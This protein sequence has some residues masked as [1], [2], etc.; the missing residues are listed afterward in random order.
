MRQ[1]S[2]SLGL[3]SSQGQN[4]RSPGAL[5]ADAIGLTAAGGGVVLPLLATQILRINLV[6]D[7]APALAL[8]VDSADEDI[9]RQSPRPRTEGVITRH[10]WIGI[11]FVGAIMATGTLLVL[12]ASLPG[13]LIEG[14]G[15]MR[16][17][18]TMAFTTL[19]MFQLFNV[20]NARSDEQSACHGFFRNSFQVKT[21]EGGH[22]R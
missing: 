2:A 9:M 22:D 21:S 11:F 16:Y 13:G 4:E 1:P 12:D 17:A 15:K 7:G 10:M 3:I 18:Q 6:T 5:P 19:M 20:F 8:G 14:G